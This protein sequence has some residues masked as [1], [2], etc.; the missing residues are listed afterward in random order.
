MRLTRSNAAVTRWKRLHFQRIRC[1]QCGR[2]VYMTICKI[3]EANVTLHISPDLECPHS[4]RKVSETLPAMNSEANILNMNSFQK[5]IIITSTATV[6]YWAYKRVEL[7]S[8]GQK[9]AKHLVCLW[10]N[11]RRERLRLLFDL[12][13]SNAPDAGFERVTQ[14]HAAIRLTNHLWICWYS[15]NK[16]LQWHPKRTKAFTR[17]VLLKV[18]FLVVVR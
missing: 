14:S 13:M 10:I 8:I 11:V 1:L 15:K 6:L 4:R 3:R 12:C 16:S 7:S 17:G 18:D 5:I 9:Q 2:S